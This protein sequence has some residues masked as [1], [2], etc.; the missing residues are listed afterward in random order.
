MSSFDLGLTVERRGM[1]ALLPHLKQVSGHGG[2]SLTNKGPLSRYVQDTLG[3][4]V[5]NTPDGKMW[6]VEIKIEETNKTGN[7]FLETWSNLNFQPRKVGW[8]YTQSADILWYYTTTAF[9]SGR[10]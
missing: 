1:A 3:D 8:I 5:L 6:W 4:V 2:F 7:L 10:T 9:L